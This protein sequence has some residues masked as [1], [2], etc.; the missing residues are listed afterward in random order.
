MVRVGPTTVVLPADSAY[1]ARF[2]NAPAKL[3]N[4]HLFQ[5][6]YYLPK[7]CRST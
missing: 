2:S 5:P 4:H 3:F 7:G 6:Y 1:Y